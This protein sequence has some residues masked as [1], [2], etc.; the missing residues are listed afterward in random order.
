MRIHK[1][2]LALFFA[3]A[4]SANIARAADASP[5]IT[6]RSHVVVRKSEIM[7]A[8]LL[9]AAASQSLK[10]LAAKIDLG[11]AP[12]PGAVLHVS[13]A[14][15][16]AAIE[17]Q[18]Q[19]S[20]ELV[21]PVSLEVERFH[22][23]LSSEEI[24]DALNA[25]ARRRGLRGADPLGLGGTELT[26]PVTVTADQPDLRVISVQPNPAR[27]T[28]QFQLVAASEPGLVPF[29]VIVPRLVKFP[30]AEVAKA[31]S[32]SR[33]TAPDWANQAKARRSPSMASVAPKPIP[34]Q[35]P[36]PKPILVEPGALATLLVTGKGF[37]IKAVVIP[38]Q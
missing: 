26:A 18:P 20:Q 9:P 8:D 1:A 35:P 21:L 4:T 11:S 16:Q 14:Q 13:R 19:L 15:I 7:L 10:G 24:A 33:K 5:K 36:K 29:S 12:Q 22:R 3:A 17:D 27:R 38:L 2:A 31:R 25:E 28:T 30:D 6:L 23:A 32:A 37:T 34:F